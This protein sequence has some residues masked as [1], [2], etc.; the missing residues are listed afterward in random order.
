VVRIDTLSHHGSTQDQEPIVF[1]CK[2]GR[3]IL[4]A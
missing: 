3:V 2:D 4:L 1:L